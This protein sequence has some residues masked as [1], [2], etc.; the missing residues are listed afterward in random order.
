[1]K[2]W[3]IISFLFLLFFATNAFAEAVQFYFIHPGG[4][5]DTEEAKPYIAAFYDYLKEQTG[6]S[7]DGLYLNDKDEA[8]KALKNKEIMLAI[9]SPEFFSKHKV[10][11]NLNEIL[12]TIPSYSSGPY[13]KY[14]IM[15]NK[16]TKLTHLVNTTRKTQLFVSQ[17][18]DSRFLNNVIFSENKMIQKIPWNLEETPNVLKTLRKINSG[19]KDTFVLLTGYEFS[20]INKLRKRSQDFLELK[21][22][23]SSTELPS[24]TVV[25]VGKA[26]ETDIDKIKRSLLTMPST[27]NGNLILKR[28]RLKGFTN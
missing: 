24:S 5:G 26:T 13:E 19:E 12:K 7:F 28:L 20:V 22:V 18:Y 14:F 1:V 15:T 10:K 8:V 17:K 9:V 11:Y 21:L 27:L 16:D 2:K 4:E 6:L 3:L 25:V 23:F